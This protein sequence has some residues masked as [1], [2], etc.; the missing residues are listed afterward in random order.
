[1]NR[2]RNQRSIIYEIMREE[3]L[4]IAIKVII[5]GNGGECCCA[6]KSLLI[7]FPKCGMKNYDKLKNE[8]NEEMRVKS[9]AI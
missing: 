1:V 2:E 7:L 6:S 5:V 3:E 9:D 8:M 4:E